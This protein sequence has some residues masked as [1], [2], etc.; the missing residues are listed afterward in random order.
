MIRPGK[1]SADR[2]CSAGAD[3]PPD[4]HEQA[5]RTA[6]RLGWAKTY[7]AEYLVLA[8]ALG[9]PLLTLDE[10]LIRGAGHLV[11]MVRPTEIE[12]A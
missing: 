6:A 10:R 3:E 4:H 2:A 1:R 12:P 5:L 11:R 9:A 8:H 7:D